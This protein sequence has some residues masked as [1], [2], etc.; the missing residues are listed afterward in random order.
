MKL[1][2]AVEQGYR[3]AYAKEIDGA[4]SG[5]V[6]ILSHNVYQD[7]EG[8]YFSVKSDKRKKIMKIYLTR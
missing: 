3:V 2:D 7:G 6:D 8:L 1:K 4:V 5:K